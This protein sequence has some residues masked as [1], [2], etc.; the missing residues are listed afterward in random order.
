MIYKQLEF[1]ADVINEAEYE[2]RVILG[3]K[4]IG[5]KGTESLSMEALRFLDKGS[6]EHKESS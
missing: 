3:H 1:D 6:K 4:L 2:S 5:I